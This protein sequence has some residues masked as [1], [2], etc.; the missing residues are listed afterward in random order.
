MSAEMP[1]IRVTIECGET[2]VVT[3]KSRSDKHAATAAIASAVGAFELAF[4]LFGLAEDVGLNLV[5]DH[6]PRDNGPEAMLVK[7]ATEL[8]LESEA[9]S[10]DAW[11]DIEDASKTLLSRRSRAE[12][13]R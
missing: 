4:E 11:L 1:G 8:Y 13:S 3:V 5:S 7:A 10:D 9:T 12:E 6:V 2:K